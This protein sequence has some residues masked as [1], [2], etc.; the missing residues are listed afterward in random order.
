MLSS[1]A[2]LGEYRVLLPA[3]HHLHSHQVNAQWEAGCGHCFYLCNSAGDGFGT[4]SF[5]TAVVHDMV[6]GSV[7]WG[8]LMWRTSMGAVLV[9]L[10]FGVLHQVLG[11][12]SVLHLFPQV[13]GRM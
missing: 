11:R 8:G 9:E 13:R 3:T 1:I 12:A 10:G 4:E 5:G 2:N 6:R 7:L